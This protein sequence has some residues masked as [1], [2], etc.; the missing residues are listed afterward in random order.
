MKRLFILLTAMGISWAATAQTAAQLEMLKQNP[1]LA[2]QLQQSSATPSSATPTKTV[3]ISESTDQSREVIEPTQAEA[4]PAAKEGRIVYGHSLFGQKNLT[5]APSM[6]M[7]TPENYVLSSGDQLFINT[8]GASENEY[9]VKVSPD[10]YVNLRNIGLIAVKGLTIQAAESRIKSNMLEKMEGINDGAIKIN[11]SLGDI[12]SIKVNIA[13]EAKVPGTY[14]LPSL[15]TL[16]NAMYVAGGVSEIGSV[17]EIKLYRAG[18][19]IATLDVYDYLLKGDLNVDKRL[20]DNDLIVIEPYHN[21][22]QVSGQV[23]R[24]MYYELKSNETL[25]TLFNFAGGFKGNAFTDNVTV[26]RSA[27]GS[28][29]QVFSVAR[30]GFEYFPMMDRDQVS[31]GRILETYSNKL[32]ITGPVWR[33]GDYE[34]NEKTNSV[35][36]LVEEAQGP[37]ENAFLGRAHI[38][39]LKDDYTRESIAINLGDILSGK[40]S[41]VSLLP[42]DILRITAYNDLFVEPTITIRGQVNDPTTI[43]YNEGVTLLDA[44]MRGKGLTRAA[45]LA[46]VEVSRRVSSPY[47][48]SPSTTISESFSFK[49]SEDLSLTSNSEN[50]KL[51]PFDIITVR[52]S[53]GYMAQQA[54]Y[55][56]GEVVF[57]GQYTLENN[58]TRLS[59]LVKLAGG[60]T[61]EA[62]VRGAHLSRQKTDADIERDRTIAKMSKDDALLNSDSIAV[63]IIGVGD[64]YTVG[65]DLEA[66]LNNPKGDEDLVLL[67]GDRLVIPTY[68]NTVKV[69][70]SVYFPNAVTYTSGLRV[71]DYIAQAGGYTKRSIRRPFVIYQN[72]M[73]AT[74]NATVEPGCEIVV[75]TKPARTPMS[76][77]E[78]VSISSSVVS[79]AA[80]V[81]SLLK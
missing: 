46:R 58:K 10:G 47:A 54:V 41:D 6:D 43:T 29:K 65:I 79:M 4:A 38:M 67:K 44:I 15:A 22:V 50:F 26:D 2:Q 8:W 39:R 64:Y 80:M 60:L 76:A 35:K 33:T 49:I 66:A 56:E 78:W 24:P 73:I 55:M 42:D 63:K 68:L 37:R 72:G 70:G 45:S 17:R 12:R 11:I 59:D 25:S 18:K 40:A 9:N 53:P 14:T 34:L 52:R 74:K 13:G 30:Q 23:K 57:D 69:S 27:T 5:F 31:V 81:T 32:T 75:P 51:M 48:T 77:G 28:E 21:L 3:I 19:L 7:P 16:F 62:N 71:K 36:K 61:E 20:E 1:E